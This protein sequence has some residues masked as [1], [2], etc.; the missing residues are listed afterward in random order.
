M[1]LAVAARWKQAVQRGGESEGE[2][3]LSL[4]VLPKLLQGSTSPVSCLQV[5]P[6]WCAAQIDQDWVGG[7]TLWSSQSLQEGR[8][9]PKCYICDARLL[10]PGR[11]QFPVALLPN[12]SMLAA[13]WGQPG[14][15]E[16]V[17]LTATP[18]SWIIWGGWAVFVTLLMRIWLCW[19]ST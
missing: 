2:E 4:A 19:A 12:P 3:P 10:W 15:R 11:G 6:C 9:A 18:H 17:W 1:C 5:S 16:Q 14:C 7:G 8:E 13:A